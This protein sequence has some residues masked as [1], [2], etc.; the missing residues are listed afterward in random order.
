MMTMQTAE[1]S[2]TEMGAGL[3]GAGKELLAKYVGD[4]AA[5]ESHIEEAI[6]RQLGM[7]KG[8]SQ[9][10]PL[11]R[12]FHDTIRQQRDTMIQL[13]DDLGS[14]AANP[15]KEIGGEILGKAAGLIDKVR[16]DSV[17][18]ALRD[19]YTAFNLAAVSYSMLYT[20]AKAVGSQPVASAA[21]TALTS[22]A[23]LVQKINQVIPD[24]VLA[25]ISDTD[26]LT[27]ATGVAD[28][29]RK[30]VNT[31]WKSTDQSGMKGNS[32]HS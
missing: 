30:M 14:N 2:S 6:D 21:K 25:E 32:S 23:G 31:A 11:V 4:M 7:T 13:R 16:A 9:V 22:Y 17:S 1:A 5:L 26:G 15:I 29:T 8:D 18:K 28:D 3:S 27:V 20:T 19:D 24:V 12:E 10:G